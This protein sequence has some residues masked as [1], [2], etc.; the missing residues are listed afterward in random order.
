[1]NTALI[2]LGSNSNPEENIELAIE[3]LNE[4]FE[5]VSISSPRITKPAGDAYKADFHNVALKLLSVETSD[6]TR[7]IFK[8]I[9]KETGRTPESK[10]QGLIPIDIDMIFWNETQVHTDYD[11]FDF[12]KQCIDEI[13]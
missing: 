11:R 6:E 1:M 3:K 7:A 2:M 10:Q 13:I 12:V 5:V 9:E 4:Y 8:Q